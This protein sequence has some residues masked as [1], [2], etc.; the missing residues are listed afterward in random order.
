MQQITTPRFTSSRHNRNDAHINSW[1]DNSSIH[2]VCTGLRQMVL[3][4]RWGRR[5]G[6]TIPN[7]KAM[8]DWYLI[9]KEQLDFSNSFSLDIETICKEGSVPSSRWPTSSKRKGIF[10]FL[11]H[12]ALFKHIFLHYFCLHTMFSNLFWWFFLHMSFLWFF[13]WFFLI[14]LFVFCFV[15]FMKREK[16]KNVMKLIWHVGGRSRRSQESGSNYQKYCMKKC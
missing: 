7:Q 16:E 3:Q 9:T 10:E 13:L 15:C 11:S 12:I 14:F 6:V 8:S 1:R 5:T 4:H 2:S